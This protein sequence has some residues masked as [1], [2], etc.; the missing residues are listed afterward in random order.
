MIAFRNLSTPSQGRTLLLALNVAIPI[1]VVFGYSPAIGIAL[2]ASVVAIIAF[3]RVPLAVL[4]FAQ[5]SVAVSFDLIKPLNAHG[6]AIAQQV[7]VLL[8]AALLPML[9]AR[10]FRNRQ[11]PLPIVAYGSVFVF[12]FTLSRKYEDLS[13]KTSF[14]NLL[15]LCLPW[16]ASQINWR[17]GEAKKALLAIALVAPL[18]VAIGFPL[19]LAGLHRFYPAEFTGVH[20]LRGAT[21][22]A[23]LA[24]IGTGGVAAGAALDRL[25]WR[26]RGSVLI[27]A[28]FIIVGLTATRGGLIACIIILMPYTRRLIRNA[29]SPEMRTLSLIGVIGVIG[30]A[31]AIYLPPLLER[32]NSSSKAATTISADDAATSGRSEAWKYF[33]SQARG[34]QNFGRGLG[35]SPLIGEAAK[36]QLPG[37]FRAPHNEYIRTYLETGYFGT[38]LIF[39][40]IAIYVVQ[41]VR[42]TRP[43]FRPDLIALLLAFFIYALT[44]NPMSGQHLALPFGLII[45]IYASLRIPGSAR[46]GSDWGPAAVAFNPALRGKRIGTTAVD[47][48]AHAGV[49]L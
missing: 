12:T 27:V 32:T 18:S 21:E 30:V 4:L 48:L 19:E 41:L 22:A 6:P 1:A 3:I 49:D 42:W 14:I 20:R 10:G 33:I 38:F 45:G 37:D 26:R 9:I 2:A 34:S 5:L 28:N 17:S 8:I 43:Y 15:V 46:P 25:G 7:R 35:S 16:I 11:I 40:A 13:I 47:P 31:V 44:D 36:D 23:F 39:G 29:R 24:L